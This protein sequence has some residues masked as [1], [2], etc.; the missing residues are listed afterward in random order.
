MAKREKSWKSLKPKLG[1]NW[2]KKKDEE[3]R[4]EAV[5]KEQEVFFTISM[6]SIFMYNVPMYKSKFVYFTITKDSH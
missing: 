2:D 4:K 1:T 5:D 6:H 3:F